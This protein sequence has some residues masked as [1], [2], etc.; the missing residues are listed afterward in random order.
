VLHKSKKQINQPALDFFIGAAIGTIGLSITLK[1][2]GK[3][4]Y[5]LWIGQLAA[6]LLLTGIYKKITK[7]KKND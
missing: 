6:P 2:L 3:S 1:Y 7:T 4:N 5:S